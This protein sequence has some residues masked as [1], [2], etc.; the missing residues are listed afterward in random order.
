MFS[1]III[2]CLI[3]CSCFQAKSQLFINNNGKKISLDSLSVQLLLQT[4]IDDKKQLHAAFLNDTSWKLIN[5]K[6]VSLSNL[7]NSISF[8]IDINA[9][10]KYGNFNYLVIHN[11]QINYIKIWV[12]IKDS[13]IKEFK[14]TGDHTAFASRPIASSYFV[15]PI[16][17]SVFKDASIILTVDKSNEPLYVSLDF[18]ND[19][20]YE[21]DKQRNN[22]NIGFFIGVA[23]ILI[24]FNCFLYFNIKEK[25]YLFYSAYVFIIIAYLIADYGLFFMHVIESRFFN[26]AIRPFLLVL[27]IVPLTF[28]LNELLSLKNKLPKISNFLHYYILFYVLFSFIMLLFSFLHIIFNLTQLINIKLFITYSTMVI[29]IA[30]A[31]YAY[32]KKIKFAGFIVVALIWL[33]IFFSVYNSFANGNL[34]ENYVTKNAHYI[35]FLGEVLIMLSAMVWR[36]KLY[37]N[38]AQENLIEN[39]NLQ[40]R[41]FNEV[42]QYQE[43]EMKRMSSFFHDTLGAD[44]GLLRLEVDNM[45]LTEEGRKKVAKRISLV[46]NDVRNIS[47][48]LSPIILEDNGLFVTIQEMILQIKQSSAIDLQ[49]E[50]IGEHKKLSLQYEIL[51]YKIVR[52]ILQNII[53]HAKLNG[54]FLQIITEDNL[55]SIYS[56][57]ELDPHSTIDNSGIGL[58]SMEDLVKILNGN[59]NVQQNDDALFRISI[60]FKTI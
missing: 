49:F 19:Y 48:S 51:I 8:K 23:F 2:C 29:L 25:L 31:G 38:E 21:V 60:E 15:F 6:M 32:Y 13:V 33:M 10:S 14:I 40:K 7:P 44:I 45:L 55:V 30:I 59:F 3:L 24:L 4:P 16:S 26:D 56:E 52:E 17:S 1:R 34:S 27:M 53:K 5:N 28:F 18:F 37:K 47:H 36:F 42:A 54:A 11:A 50:W 46:G 9:I 39:N 43:K 20:Y 35:A 58:K 22:I 41:I 57:N 12:K